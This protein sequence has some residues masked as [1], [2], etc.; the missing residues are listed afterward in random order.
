MAEGEGMFAYDYN[1][2]EL[3]FSLSDWSPTFF[4]ICLVENISV[5]RQKKRGGEII[6]TNVLGQLANDEFS[7]DFSETT[8]ITVIA[9]APTEYE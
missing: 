8:F 4:R 3:V 5:N 7:K 2:H 9:D 1:K 6:V